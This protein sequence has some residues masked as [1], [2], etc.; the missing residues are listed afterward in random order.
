MAVTKILIQRTIKP[1]KEEEFKQLMRE[2]R[3]RAMHAEGFISG[4]TLQSVDDPKLHVTIST[5]K[6][7]T[8]WNNWVNSTERKETQDKLDKVLA[9]PTKMTPFHYE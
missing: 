5:W 8:F 4:E 3:T 9:E 7:I 6:N 1:G 2:L